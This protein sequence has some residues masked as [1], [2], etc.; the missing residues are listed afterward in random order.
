MFCSVNGGLAALIHAGEAATTPWLVVQLWV[1]LCQNI[2]AHLGEVEFAVVLV[3]RL[4]CIAEN[5]FTAA[6]VD[7][8]FCERDLKKESTKTRAVWL[9]YKVMLFGIYI[10]YI[11]GSSNHLL[12]QIAI[13]LQYEIYDGF[14]LP[15]FTL[16]RHMKHR[17][18]FAWTAF[19]PG[20]PSPAGAAVL[21]GAAGEDVAGCDGCAGAG[22]AEGCA[23][24]GVEG[25]TVD[26][27]GDETAAGANCVRG[28]VGWVIF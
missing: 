2:L 7:S 1:S 24:G 25:A 3:D 27:V 16:A 14:G 11:R 15:F 19:S 26:V 10:Q 17:P 21:A 9:G 5:I 28:R 13:A 20:A 22:A 4:V 23:V 12:N 8:L 6:L 18:L